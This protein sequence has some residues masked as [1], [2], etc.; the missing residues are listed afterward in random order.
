MMWS[1]EF[2]C[3][4]ESGGGRESRKRRGEED[5]GGGEK[6]ILEEHAP[7]CP[8]SSSLQ[9]GLTDV[10]VFV[11]LFVWL[12]LLELSI[13]FECFISAP[14]QNPERLF[15]YKQT[16]RN[17]CVCQDPNLSW[18]VLSN[19]R[20]IGWYLASLAFL[21]ISV[22]K[23][24]KPFPHVGSLTLTPRGWKLARSCRSGQGHTVP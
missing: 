20:G 8:L 18:E 4:S 7:I 23:S 6:R 12:S 19:H 2:E 22:P 15:Q 10:R 24:P 17:P 11:C 16:P 21:R 5:W 14:N 3:V 1:L 13:W 9:D